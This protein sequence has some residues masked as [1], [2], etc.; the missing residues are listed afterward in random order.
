M[1]LGQP[2]KIPRKALEIDCL[3]VASV[4]ASVPRPYLTSCSFAGLLGK[5]QS[6]CFHLSW[7]H[8]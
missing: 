6:R 7:H 5:C 8:R 4:R 2:G 1:A 3:P